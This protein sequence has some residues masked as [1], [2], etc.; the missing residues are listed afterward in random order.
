MFSEDEYWDSSDSFGSDD[1]KEFLQKVELEERINKL[2]LK[3]SQ[4]VF[5]QKIV[6]DMM[7]FEKTLDRIEQKMDDAMDH[8]KTKTEFMIKMKWCVKLANRNCNTITRMFN[9]TNK[10]GVNTN[11][12]KSV[13]SQM[14]HESCKVLE[15]LEKIVAKMEN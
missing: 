15:T 7:E 6:G 13:L 12:F 1:A 9:G 5:A 14:T 4:E 2:M 8:A 3:K 11:E 10:K